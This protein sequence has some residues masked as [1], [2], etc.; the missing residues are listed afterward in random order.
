LAYNL[1]VA[2]ILLF[3]EISTAKTVD[4]QP[5]VEIRGN[6]FYST[7]YLLA[8]TS[9]IT[10]QQSVERLIFRILD[11]YNNTGFPFCRIIP[12]LVDDDS[13]PARIVLTVDEGPRV[14][15]DDL[16]FRTTGRTDWRAAK[17]LANLR[18]GLYFS[19]KDTE[20][21]KK[22]LM[23]TR[24]FEAIDESVLQRDGRH[25]LMLTA[26]EKESDFLTLSGSFSG[27]NTDNMNFGASFS[28]F[29]V[30]GT[31]RKLDFEYEYQRLFLIKFREPVLIAPAQL[32]ADF[33]I[34]T[35]DSTRLTNGRLEFAAPF[36]AYFSIS[37]LSGIELVNYYGNDTTS[38][39]S[40]DNLLGIGLIYDYARPE[41]STLQ[42]IKLDYLF[43]DADRLRIAY[44][45][46][47]T[48]W[49]FVIRPHYHRVQTDIL[50]FFDYLR[51]GGAKDLRGYLEDEFVTSRALWCNFEYHRLFIFPLVD[52]ARI[53][54]EVFYSYGFGISAKSRFADATLVLAWPKGGTWS[55]GKVHLTFARGF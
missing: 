5:L 17:R 29:N 2:T 4:E 16:L 20:M 12:S 14:I 3:S 43:R 9:R 11:I 6:V 22:R 48:L 15:I 23:K 42:T 51:I 47:V 32:D 53:G 21:A 24:A 49:K 27:P 39:Q 18:K 28:S 46:E 50:Q 30:L 10:S 8:R 36:A 7:Q 1:L 52:I 45:G 41:W 25:Y 40:S 44:D 55:D 19:R 31:L 37:L 26:R 13:K 34:L 33:S 38:R 35:Y 54:Q